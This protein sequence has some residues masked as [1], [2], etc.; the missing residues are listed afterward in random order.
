MILLTEKDNCNCRM[1]KSTRNW[2]CMLLC[3]PSD[4]QKI[5]NELHIMH[6]SP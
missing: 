2:N 3:K 5:L 6:S 4:N 1:L